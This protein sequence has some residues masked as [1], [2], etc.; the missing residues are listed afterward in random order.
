MKLS[1]PFNIIPVLEGTGIADSFKLKTKD[2]KTLVDLGPG[3]DEYFLAVLKE[4]EAELK[5]RLSH[6]TAQFSRSPLPT[7]RRNALKVHAELLSE[8]RVLIEKARHRE[9]SVRSSR[10]PA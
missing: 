5:Y 1:L 3:E 9:K 8:A 7:S 10:P 2:G 4:L 6:R